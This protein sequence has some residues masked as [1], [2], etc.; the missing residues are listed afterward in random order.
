MGHDVIVLLGVNHKTTPLAV[1][2]KLALTSG[3]EEPLALLR[4]LDG[5]SEY[6]LLSTCNR[7]EILFTCQD[8]VQM[9][10]E[11]LDL[12]FAGNVT[13]E[14]VADCIYTYENKEAVEHLFMV[15]SSLDS[16]IVGE[17]QILGQ[18][19]E[20]FRH[21]SEQKTSGLILNKLLHKRR[22]RNKRVAFSTCLIENLPVVHIYADMVTLFYLIRFRQLKNRQTHIESVSVKNTRKCRRHNSTYTGS[23]QSDRGM[24]SAAA[25]SIRSSLTAW[26]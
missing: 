19:K 23:L 10:R 18:L 17:A 9:R 6:Y 7:V 24:L 15:A 14:E 8:P 20:A 21:A 3:Y 22:Y 16:M 26:A 5:L 2:E 13:R 25:A 4:S 12:L 11:V 1:R